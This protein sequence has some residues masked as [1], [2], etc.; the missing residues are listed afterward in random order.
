MEFASFLYSVLGAV[1]D[2]AVQRMGL[3]RGMVPEMTNKGKAAAEDWLFCLQANNGMEWNGIIETLCRPALLR[4]D[5]L[6]SSIVF[7]FRIN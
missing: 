5:S 7:F 3:G 4:R 6:N 1:A 2:S